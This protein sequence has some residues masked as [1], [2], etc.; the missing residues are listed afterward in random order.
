MGVRLISSKKVSFYFVGKKEEDRKEKN[1]LALPDGS[2][3]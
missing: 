3:F 2:R 1:I